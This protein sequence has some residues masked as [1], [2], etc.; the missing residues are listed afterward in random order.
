VARSSASLAAPTPSRRDGESRSI[1]SR[2]RYH[3]RDRSPPSSHAAPIAI[4]AA[5]AN[6]PEREKKRPGVSPFEVRKI[7]NPGDE[8]GRRGAKLKGQG[9]RWRFLRRCWLGAEGGK[10]ERTRSVLRVDLE[11]TE[12][13]AARRRRLDVAAAGGWSS[14]GGRSA[15]RTRDRN[16]GRWFAFLAGTV[17]RSSPN[18]K[19]ARARIACVSLARGARESSGSAPR[20]KSDIFR[21]DAL[22]LLLQKK[23]S[24]FPKQC[25][26]FAMSVLCAFPCPPFNHKQKTLRKSYENKR[27]TPSFP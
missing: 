12:R 10:W 1:S 27:M 9:F 3:D 7:R 15:R 11:R 19:A 25:R 2:L 23:R 13:E 4:P 20:W 5:A 8:V 22:G 24:C 26:F 18:S 16:G 17:F 6:S 21:G 14:R